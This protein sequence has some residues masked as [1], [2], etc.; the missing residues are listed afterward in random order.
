MEAMML[1]SI[2]IFSAAIILVITGVIDSVIAAFL[3]I[4]AMIVFGV[5]TDLDAFKVVD[6][7]V[8]F[9]LIGIWIIAIYLG[10]TGLAWFQRIPVQ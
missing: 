6:W 10:K 5:M 2:I 9:I 1:T 8:I 3:G 7:N 4:L